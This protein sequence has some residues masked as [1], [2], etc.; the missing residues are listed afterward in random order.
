MKK[1]VFQIVK[2]KDLSGKVFLITGGYA[3]LG[4]M[5]SKALL[6]ANAT[7]I[8]AGRNEKT[9]EEFVKSLQQE[10]SPQR[11]KSKTTSPPPVSYPNC[12]LFTAPLFHLSGLYIDDRSVEW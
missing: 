5:S 7:V 8:I 2:G 6:S 1:T 12:G 4:A 3:G 10:K 9:Q 11:E